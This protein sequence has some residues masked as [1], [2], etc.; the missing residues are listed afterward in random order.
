MLVALYVFGFLAYIGLFAKPSL[1]RVVRIR[2]NGDV[3]VRREPGRDSG[4]DCI[5][6]T[7]HI[8][9]RQGDCVLVYYGEGIRLDR[10]TECP[11]KA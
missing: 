4:F 8:R 5:P 7:K 2:P 9:V 1:A 11:P 6:N 3:C 10:R